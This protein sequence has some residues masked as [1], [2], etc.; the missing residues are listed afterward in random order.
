MKKSILTSTLCLAILTASQYSSAGTTEL[1]QGAAFGGTAV[2]GAIAGG[3]IGFVAGAITGALIG[4]ELKAADQADEAI[5][6][7]SNEV[8]TLKEELSMNQAMLAEREKSQD[9]MADL[10]QNLPNEVYFESNSDE[11]TPDAESIIAVLAKLIQQD[12]S[13]TVDVV[14]HTDPRG[15]DE[16]NNVLSQYRAEAVVAK[17][18]DCGVPAYRISSKGEGS[19]QSTSMKGDLD[20][21]ALERRVDIELITDTGLAYQSNF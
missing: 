9:E 7:A 6:A 11:L 17:L 1:K 10:L 3:P 19:N 20:S 21:Y 16:Y 8:I 2:L 15:T 12:P 5:N 4:E 18:I 14:G 13:I